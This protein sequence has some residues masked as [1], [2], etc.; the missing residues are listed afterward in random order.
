MIGDA[1]RAAGERQGAPVLDEEPDEPQRRERAEHEARGQPARL[2]EPVGEVGGIDR[3][4]EHDRRQRDGE[5][6][7]QSWRAPISIEPSVM[8]D[9][10]ELPVRRARRLPVEQHADAGER[11]GDPDGQVRGDHSNATEPDGGEER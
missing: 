10:P 6:A 2:R 5:H 7:R 8:L 1:T 11:R 4:E 3:D 9:E